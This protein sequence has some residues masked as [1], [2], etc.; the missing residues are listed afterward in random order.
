MNFKFNKSGFNN[1]SKNYFK[2]S[3]FNGKS[4]LNLFNCHLNTQRILTCINNKIFK[5]NVLMINSNEKLGNNN[6]NTKILFGTSCLNFDLSIINVDILNL[7]EADIVSS[8][9]EIAKLKGIIN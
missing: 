2:R 5:N 3:F 9:S 4:Y 8:N 7:L 1:F 6:S